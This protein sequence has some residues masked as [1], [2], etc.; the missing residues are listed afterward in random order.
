MHRAVPAPQDHLG[1]AQLL[2]GQA[3]VRLV[4]VVEHAVVE[5]RSPSPARAVLRP[6]VLVG[7]EEHPLAPLERPVQR[8]LGVGRGAD[9]AA[10]AADEALDVGRGVH[11]GHRHGRVGDA[12]RRRACPRPSR[13]GRSTAMSAIEQPA[14]RSGRITCCASAGEDVGALGHE[15]HA[16]EHDELRVGPG[17]RLAGQLERVAGHV[18]ELDD[19]VAL[20][21]VAEHEHPVAERRLGGAWRGR[22][23]RGR[24]ARAGRPGSRR[25]ARL[26]GS[27]PRPS[28]S[29][30]VAC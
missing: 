5:R 28:S 21:V 25:R 20:V 19:L 11:V 27:L 1:V 12:Q 13:P 10:V 30:A 24:W 23:D 6:E 9:H 8:A 22:P 16:A 15:V 7:Q 29:R 3:A 2:G 14:A 17:R 18:G 4:R 26:A